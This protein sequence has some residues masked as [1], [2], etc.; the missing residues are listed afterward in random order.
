VDNFSGEGVEKYCVQPIR[1]EMIWI[2][3]TLKIG[4]IFARD[5]SGGENGVADERNC[6]E[7][8]EVTMALKV[9]TICRKTFR[10]EIDAPERVIAGGVDF[11]HF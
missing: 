1:A 4:N 7:I 9:G 2:I 6:V 3:A 5:E 10:L 11:L 8:R